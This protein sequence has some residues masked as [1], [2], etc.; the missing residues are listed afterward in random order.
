MDDPYPQHRAN[1]GVV[2]FNAEGLVW[3]GRR[4]D[5]D[6]PHIWQFPQGGMD[7]GEDAEAA[8]RREVYEETGARSDQLELLGA[9]DH[10][11]AYDFPPGL[12]PRPDQKRYK[13]KGQKQRWFAF[14]YTGKDADFD[15]TAVPP[16]EFA[17]WRWEKLAN[18]PPLI[19][20]WKRAV[21]EEVVEAFSAF[22][23]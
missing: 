1:A 17:E 19:I 4:A 21:Y 15:L 11:I 10:W 7:K 20:D 8:A 2:L 3:I 16:Q 22:A 23:R 13:W 14:R 5:V 9:I 12:P 6:G 18:I